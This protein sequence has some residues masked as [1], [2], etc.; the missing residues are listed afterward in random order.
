MVQ[1]VDL[2][3]LTLA[4]IAHR[5]TQETDLFFQRQRYDPRYCLELFRRAIVE[6]SE[7][8][9]K[10]IYIQYRPL[11]VGWTAR[12]PAF[13]D[14]GEE[15]QFFVNRAFE[16]MWSALS[17]VKFGRFPNLK[18]VLRYLQM[19]VN[20]VIIDHVRKATLV[21]VSIDE[22][23]PIVEEAAHLQHSSPQPLDMVHR[24]EFWQVVQ[25]RLNNEQE[26]KVVYGSFL[27]GLKPREV[28]AQ[29]QDIFADVREVYRVKENVLGRLRRD[30]DLKEL[31]LGDA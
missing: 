29:Y 9:W 26:R 23:G 17:P 24:Q 1:Q 12:H 30:A 8:A 11:V 16:R 3:Q 19:C 20:S 27:L 10:L 21:Q 2:H 5:C 28:C 13:G 18:S 6:H 14:C 31:L 7:K 15:V 4:G 25:S 22:V